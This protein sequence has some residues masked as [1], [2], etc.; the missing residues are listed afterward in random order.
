MWVTVLLKIH[1]FLIK[2]PAAP[3]PPYTISDFMITISAGE[4]AFFND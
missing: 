1:P 2:S 4:P 3:N